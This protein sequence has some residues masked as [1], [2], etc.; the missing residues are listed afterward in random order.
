[1]NAID[2]H[3]IVHYALPYYV[4]SRD[5]WVWE[6]YIVNAFM[7]TLWDFIVDFDYDLLQ[8]KPFGV[9]LFDY[10]VGRLIPE[11]VS[12][13]DYAAALRDHS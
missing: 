7:D 6:N 2:L 10:F 11:G 9:D 1:M 12:L 5:I 3:D 13:K 8:N 4:L